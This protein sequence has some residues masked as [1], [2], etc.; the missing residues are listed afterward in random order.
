[1]TSLDGRLGK[2]GKVLSQVLGIP[3]HALEP[4][5]LEVTAEAVAKLAVKFDIERLIPEGVAFHGFR[6][7]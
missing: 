5:S 4:E 2:R 1:L 3:C 7:N 6:L